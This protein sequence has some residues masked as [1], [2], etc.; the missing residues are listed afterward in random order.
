MAPIKVISFLTLNHNLFEY[1]NEVWK[2]KWRH[3]V[4]DCGSNASRFWQRENVQFIEPNIWP[5]AV[6]ALKF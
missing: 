6:L 4:N 3:L 2:I 1:L 5:G